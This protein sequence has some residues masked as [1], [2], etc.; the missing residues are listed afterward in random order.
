[1]TK[2]NGTESSGGGGGLPHPELSG[3]KHLGS[4]DVDEEDP[5]RGDNGTKDGM[6]PK[7]LAPTP[8][9]STRAMSPLDNLVGTSLTPD[10]GPAV[11]NIFY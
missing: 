2:A 10:P 9:G 8:A 7:V 3:E 1:M 5:A 11:I 4:D 6:A